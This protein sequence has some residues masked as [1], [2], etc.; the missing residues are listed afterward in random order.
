MFIYMYVIAIISGCTY[1]QLMCMPLV[2][3]CRELSHPQNGRVEFPVPIFPQSEAVYTCNTGHVLLGESLRRC[4]DDGVW[5]GNEP[6]CVGELH[7]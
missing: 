5:S 1:I 6:T 4:L 3:E 2:V 7:T